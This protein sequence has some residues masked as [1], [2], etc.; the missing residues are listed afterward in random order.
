MEN[1]SNQKV[2]CRNISLLRLGIFELENLFLHQTTEGLSTLGDSKT[3]NNRSR[4]V[5]ISPVQPNIS[6]LLSPLLDVI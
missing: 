3:V 2:T 6:E 4:E 1:K 5:N